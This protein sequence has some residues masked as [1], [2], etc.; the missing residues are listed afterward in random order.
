MGRL[1]NMMGNIQEATKWRDRIKAG[2]LTKG[3][4]QTA[5]DPA[6]RGWI[7]ERPNG[8]TE[9]DFVRA[10]QLR[11][12]N[13]PTRA[14]PSAPVGQRRCRGG[15]AVDES[16]SHVLQTCPITHWGRIRRHDETVGK[17][18]RHCKNRRWEVEEEPHVR[19]SGGQLFKS[20][21]VIHQPGGSTIVADIQVSWE[22]TELGVAYVRK[23]RKYDNPAY[24]PGSTT[25]ARMYSR[26]RLPYAVLVCTR[27]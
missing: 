1:Q 2:A 22:S 16:L 5:E 9:R 27:L 23:Q 18:A 6:S 8:W 24:G 20:D 17:I 13:L 14:I 15:C 25:Q 10:V 12:A 19:H 7:L 11:A 21:L 26:Y 3:L 4:E